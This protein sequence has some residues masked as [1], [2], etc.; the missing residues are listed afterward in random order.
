MLHSINVFHGEKD[1]DPRSC[2]SNAMIRT[3]TGKFVPVRPLGGYGL[4]F[5]LRCAALVF[6]GAAD[7]VKWDDQKV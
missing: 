3:K 1:I 2:A 6:L 7:I 4:L 5:R